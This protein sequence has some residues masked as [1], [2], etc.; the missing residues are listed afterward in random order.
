MTPQTKVVLVGVLVAYVVIYCNY[1]A[2]FAQAPTISQQLAVK[3]FHLTG[4]ILRETDK[5][6]VLS[7]TDPTRAAA[8]ESVLQTQ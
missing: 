4:T 5:S 3:G 8:D 1:S 7:V 6:I 2:A